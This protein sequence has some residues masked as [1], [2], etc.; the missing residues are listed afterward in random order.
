MVP[1]ETPEFAPDEDIIELT[2]IV[3]KGTPPTESAVDDDLFGGESD[4]DMDFEKELEDLFADTED[5]D[6]ASPADEVPA[7]PGEPDENLGDDLD[8]LLNSLDGNEPPAAAPTE[9]AEDG[10]DFE[11]ELDD[12]LEGLDDEASSEASTSGTEEETPAPETADDIDDDLDDLLAGLDDEPQTA[13][14]PAED[15][16]ATLD[17]V[18]EPTES[19]DDIDLSELDALIEDMEV[20]AKSDDIP[21]DDSLPDLS[22]IDSLLE[23]AEAGDAILSP[24]EDSAVEQEAMP[25]GIDN[26]L[27]GLEESTGSP[28][29]N[30]EETL[31]D[32]ASL[33]DLDNLL[34]DL[35]GNEIPLEAASAPEED[36]DALLNAQEEPDIPAAED[37]LEDLEDL[38]T[39][40][41]ESSP[42]REASSNAEAPEQDDLQE[43]SPE[44]DD[45]SAL[46][47]DLD[48]EDP[49]PAQ[50]EHAQEELP[51]QE[52][53]VEDI[54]ALLN[55][56]DSVEEPVEATDVDTAAENEGIAPTAEET[57]DIPDIGELDDLLDELDE[58]TAA[59]TASE[60]IEGTETIAELE[61]L[62]EA[63]VENIFDATAS[64]SSLDEMPQPTE[65]EVELHEVADEV[66][67][68]FGDEP[69]ELEKEHDVAT[70]LDDA[71]LA[72]E[73]PSPEEPATE[74]ANIPPVTTEE[75]IDAESSAETAHGSE[76]LLERIALLEASLETLQKAA[77][78]PPEAPQSSSEPLDEH[79]VEEI[80]SRRLA[81]RAA[82]EEALSAPALD[83]T[84]VESIVTE[85]LAEDSPLVNKLVTSVSDKVTTAL[86]TRL[87]ACEEA[88]FTH[89]DWTEQSSNLR[90]ELKALV[91][92]VAD[93]AAARVI[94]EEIIPALKES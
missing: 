30:L 51:T 15:I 28:E 78:E 17:P 32:E 22:D 57:L 6:D 93:E 36:I 12:L 35:G 56:F 63:P 52:E 70:M 7:S 47:D 1:N 19:S 18:E 16:A 83:R 61:D 73:T 25:D 14:S 80:I 76:E 10:L 82:E 81:E 11:S 59:D 75:Q 33:D 60:E 26:M 34:D 38:L 24:T 27:E 50:E 90:E 8:D 79:A 46:L 13:S 3:E 91:K 42:E 40:A 43:L 77:S 54:D 64:A 2:E 49:S 71:E 94:R 45:I 44:E 23:E 48:M 62:L 4:G 92:S 89:K 9:D 68:V 37:P 53:A 20:P 41:E 69:A 65:N 21:E 84:A 72:I 87:A 31:S 67:N 58:P 85:M 74:A 29:E 5:L 66:A 39:E 55:E 86:E 88:A